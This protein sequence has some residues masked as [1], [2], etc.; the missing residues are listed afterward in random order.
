MVY[1]EYF[2]H[3]TSATLPVDGINLLS[4]SKAMVRSQRA[5]AVLPIEA[6]QMVCHLIPMFKHLPVSVTIPTCSDLLDE[7]HKF[8][9]NIFATHL[10]FSFALHWSG[11][12]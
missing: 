5:F 12:I 9:F 7:S 11:L 8:Y 3:F 10:I 2:T 4:V 1:V 6:I